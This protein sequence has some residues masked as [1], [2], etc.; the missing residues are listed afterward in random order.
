MLIRTT[1]TKYKIILGVGW[2]IRVIICW[3]RTEKD[4]LYL[5]IPEFTL[6]KYLVFVIEPKK[7]LVNGLTYAPETGKLSFDGM[8]FFS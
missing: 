5:D 1:A 4:A 8:E 7:S 2:G 6:N 3:K